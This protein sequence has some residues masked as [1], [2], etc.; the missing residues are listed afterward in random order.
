MQLSCFTFPE[1]CTPLVAGLV[2]MGVVIAVLVP[3]VTVF[4]VKYFK[5]KQTQTGYGTDEPHYENQAG[6]SLPQV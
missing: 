6:S 2:V 1:S 5:L 4:G 3:L